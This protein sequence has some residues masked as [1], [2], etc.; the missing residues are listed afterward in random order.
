MQLRP[1]TFLFEPVEV[2]FERPPL[3]EKRPGCPQ[4]FA[5]RGARHE[6]VALLGEWHDYRRR[7]R[8][9]HNM[10]PAHAAAAR[11]RGSWGV[12]RDYYRVRTEAGRVF[13]LYFDRAPKGLGD[14][15][16]EWFL[17]REMGNPET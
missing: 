1:V 9:A 7:G 12:G 17:Y 4:S 2:S 13:D 16:G 14:R 11:R 8:M 5:W 6:I 15:A 3:F 10:R